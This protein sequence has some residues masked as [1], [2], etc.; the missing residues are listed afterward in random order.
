MGSTWRFWKI[1][2]IAAQLFVVLVSLYQSAVTTLGYR[3][4]MRGVP[5][6]APNGLP[7]FGLLVCARNEEEVIG[8]IVADLLNQDYPA[9]LRDV[10]VVAHNCTDNTASAAARAGA[11]VLE[12][13][14]RSA[15]KSHAV[16]AGADHFDGYD[17]VGVFDA[18]ARVSTG[19]LLAIAQHAEGA[20]C[21]QAEAVPIA[22]PDWLA[23]GYGFGRKARNVF[24]WRPREALGLTTTITGCGWFIRPE[25][26][27]R[28][29]SGQW[30]MTEDLEL[31]ARLVADGFVVRYVSSAQVAL[32]EPRDLK[33][34][35]R[36]RSRWVRGHIGVVKGRWLP[37]AR[38]GVRGNPHA[39]DMAI[40]LV[41]PTRML[42]RMGVTVAAL[43]SVL[44]APFALPGW[45]ILPAVAGE[46]VIPPWIAWRER[47][48]HLSS[49][50]L[51]LA[52]RHTLLSLL[53][54]P[55]GAW[56][57][58]TARVRAWAPTPRNS[59]QGAANVR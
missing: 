1:G 15:G 31:S 24:W 45:L 59:T 39:R 21:L 26:L 2:L 13:T 18:D 32:G 38:A 48:L 54:F 3:R 30:T 12:L 52:V 11:T 17:Y 19:L 27:H 22:D 10:L 29:R 53:W 49:G 34:S 4:Q 25:I 50:S 33:T 55:I 36:Q 57:M 40:Y 41:M 28:Y 43:L 20:D 46:W 6:R 56:A 44:S 23:E 16:Q 42:T 5:Q 51:S 58:A 37:L 7:R 9:E 35:V 8:R 47:L 14:T